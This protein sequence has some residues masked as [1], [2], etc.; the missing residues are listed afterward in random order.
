MA[1]N[2]NT[3]QL[4][5]VLQRLFERLGG[6][7]IKLTDGSNTVAVDTKMAELLGEGNV[8]NFLLGG[9]LIV[10]EDAAGAHAAPEGE[11]GYISAYD[12][13][14]TTITIETALSAP[15]GVGDKVMY[16]GSDFP[17]YDMI[18]QVNHALHHLQEIPVP[19]E[20]ITIANGQTVYDLPV[21]LRGEQLIDVLIQTNLTVGDE[22]YIPV[23]G[24]SYVPQTAPS[25]PTK[26]VLPY[27]PAGFK[28]R[29][30]YSGIHPR[31]ALWNDTISEYLHPDL[32][33]AVVFAH[34]IQWKNDQNAVQ[35]GADD[36]MLRLEQKA[37]SQ[38][39]RARIMHP[40]QIPPRRIQG[41]PHW[42]PTYTIRNYDL[43]RN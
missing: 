21:G 29:L 9:T 30:I 23:E 17:L 37:W 35:G 7:V 12:S 6:V 3:Q 28:V 16:S 24:W 27:L 25:Q 5:D 14:L 13:G 1:S 43:P 4:T 42:N 39:D 10:V 2:P 26:L 22:Q 34:A 38:F 32:V 33:H 8:D 41:M 20:S 19:D 40:P 18:E 11:V 31:V 36:S 15:M